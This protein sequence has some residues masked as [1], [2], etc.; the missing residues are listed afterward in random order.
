ME[1]GYQP[2][3]D[4]QVPGGL[5]DQGHGVVLSNRWEKVIKHA[6]LLNE[7]LAKYLEEESCSKL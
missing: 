1:E 5:R 3:N 6:Q 2:P 4:Q 7:G